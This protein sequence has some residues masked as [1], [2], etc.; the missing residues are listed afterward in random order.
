MMTELAAFVADTAEVAFEDACWVLVAMAQA[1]DPGV[2]Y[3]VWYEAEVVREDSMLTQTAVA[4]SA[5]AEVLYE[6]RWE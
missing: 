3:F 4:Y 1:F 2:A 5:D 6:R